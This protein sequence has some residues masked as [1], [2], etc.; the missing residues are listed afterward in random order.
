MPGWPR[1]A[2]LAAVAGLALLH[3]YHLLF[4]RP[5]SP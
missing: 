4:V 5:S 2:G 3:G 1:V